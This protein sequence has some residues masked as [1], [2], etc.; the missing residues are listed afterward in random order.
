MRVI[1]HEFN[2]IQADIS[3]ESVS[4]D[5][6]IGECSLFG[7]EK[8]RKSTELVEIQSS[9]QGGYKVTRRAIADASA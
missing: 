7:Q 3:A 2:L 5:L 8:I 1:S 6:I 9:E 4:C